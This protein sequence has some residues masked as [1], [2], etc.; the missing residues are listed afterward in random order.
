MAQYDVVTYAEHSLTAKQMAPGMN[1]RSFNTREVELGTNI[2][3]DPN[4]E[5]IILQPG[6][7]WIS[8]FSS[9]TYYD[10]KALDQTQIPTS[11][12]P[13]GGYC[14]LIREKDQQSRDNNLAIQVGAG[15][16]SNLIPSSV[17]IFFNVPAGTEERIVMQ[18]QIGENTDGIYLEVFS[19]GSTWRVFARLTIVRM[20]DAV[21]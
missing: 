16:D 7:Y 5:T 15:S 21:G 19:S 20:G 14:R 4:L 8:G 17:S 6:F 3:L 11:C 2:S 1:N 10:P 12:R 18:H 9:V 13:Y